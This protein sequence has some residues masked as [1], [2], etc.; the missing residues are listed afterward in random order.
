MTADR[1]PTGQWPSLSVVIPLRNSARDLPRCLDAVL[2][3]DYPGPVEVVMA[4]GPSDDGT[5]DLAAHAAEADHR[6]KI[7]PNPSGRTANALNAA[8][9]ASGGEIVARVDG[10]AILPARYLRHAVS[11]LR[12]TGADNVGGIQDATGDTTFERAVAVAMTSRFGVGNAA[13]HYG[14]EPGP[15]DTVYLGVFR[16]STLERAGGFDE[17]LVRNQDYELNWRIRDSG[18]VVWF[19]PRLRVRYRPRSS[20]RRL[21]KQYFE[22]GQ[23]KREVL[24]RHPRSARLRQLVPPAAVAANAAGL[25]LAVAG[26]RRALVI[27]GT[28]VL[29]AVTAAVVAGRT[30]GSSVTVRLPAVFAVMHHAWGLGFL[31]S[32][33]KSPRRR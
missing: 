6:I 18:G 30:A 29:G 4:V 26:R 9:A 19:D 32:R 20:L 2:T 22:Y 11:T 23:W 12:A 28:Y 15:A 1:D 25:L 21:A 8:I 27:P 13:F 24:R 16:R 31:L 10:Q 3:Q 7:V 5:D 14:G 17:T 33:R